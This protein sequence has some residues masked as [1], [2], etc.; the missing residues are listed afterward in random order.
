MP[1]RTSVKRAAPKRAARGASARRRKTAI[2]ASATP[3]RAGRRTAARKPATPKRAARRKTALRRKHATAKRATAKRATVRTSAGPALLV[4]VPRRT[5]ARVADAPRARS[6]ARA[7][8]GS[9][10]QRA[11][12]ELVRSRAVVLAAIE[13]LSAAAAVIPVAPG[14]WSV[15]EIVLH[16]AAR[17]LARLRE[18][19]AVLRGAP[20]SWWSYSD[21]EMD[22]DNAAAIESIQDLGWD[23][24][25][26]RLNTSRRELLESLESVPDEPADV[27]SPDHTFGRM[28]YGLPDHDRHHADAIR[29]WREARKL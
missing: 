29:K 26:D 14:K 24:A 18:F 6:R 3:K 28:I 21:E 25:I 19:E 20:A 1:R 2:R 23:E 22:R 16:L 17:D 11:L 9:A 27:W 7:E 8:G 10:K 12:F 5:P 13:D 4:L 15:R